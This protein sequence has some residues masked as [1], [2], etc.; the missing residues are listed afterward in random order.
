MELQTDDSAE[1]EAVVNKVEEIY[2][3]LVKGTTVLENDVLYELSE[4]KF[5]NHFGHKVKLPKTY[6]SQSSVL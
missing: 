4:S 6:V 2:E 1:H 5:Y 3:A